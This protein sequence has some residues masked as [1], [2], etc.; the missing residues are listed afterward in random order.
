MWHHVTSC[1]MKVHVTLYGIFSLR[2]RSIKNEIADKEA[3]IAEKERR[4]LEAEKQ[5][6]YQTRRLGKH[7]YPYQACASRVPKCYEFGPPIT[8]FILTQSTIFITMTLVVD[9]LHHLS[10]PEVHPLFV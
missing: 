3:A 1:D 4:R 10:T 6:P 8:R 5:S 7:S 2:L 9:L